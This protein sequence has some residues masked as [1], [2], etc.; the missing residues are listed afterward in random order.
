MRGL[1]GKEQ[2]SATGIDNRLRSRPDAP[3]PGETNRSR[4]RR[5]RGP[6]RDAHHLGI[7]RTAETGALAAHH[8]ADDFVVGHAFD[9]ARH[10]A[11]GEAQER[12]GAL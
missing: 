8:A 2:V 6:A 9:L 4:V 1:A 7:A 3:M 11:R 10:V 12:V 5:G